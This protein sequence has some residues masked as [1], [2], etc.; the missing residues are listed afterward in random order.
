MSWDGG[1]RSQC[2]LTVRSNSGKGTSQGNVVE[3]GRKD[4]KGVRV[5]AS[6]PH[7][8]ERACSPGAWERAGQTPNPPKTCISKGGPHCWS[9]AS[10]GDPLAAL[11][12][13]CCSHPRCTLC[14]GAGDTPISGG[15]PERFLSAIYLTSP[16]LRADL[17]YTDLCWDG[18][19]HPAFPSSTVDS[20]GITLCLALGR[21]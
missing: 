11:L 6:D 3:K 8:G 2:H 7:L 5:C 1:V 20:L 12:P 19:S 18:S 17:C 21:G 9:E 13:C 14:L 15:L 4:S 10:L 16:S